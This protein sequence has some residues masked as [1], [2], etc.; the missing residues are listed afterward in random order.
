MMIP[1]YYKPDSRDALPDV[2]R[3][4]LRSYY[5]LDRYVGDNQA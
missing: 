5:F 4:A 3:W 1:T 2:I